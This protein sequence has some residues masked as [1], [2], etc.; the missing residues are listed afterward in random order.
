[1]SLVSLEFLVVLECLVLLVL[2]ELLG[3]LEFQAYAGAA[4]ADW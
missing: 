2:P 1:M 4:G 3:A